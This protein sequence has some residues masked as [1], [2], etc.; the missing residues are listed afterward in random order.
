MHAQITQRTCSQE[1]IRERVCSNVA[2]GCGDDA[3]ARIDYD[4]TENEWPFAAKTMSIGSPA[5]PALLTHY[6]EATAPG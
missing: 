6:A 1:S 5:D 4:S 3:T 2:V